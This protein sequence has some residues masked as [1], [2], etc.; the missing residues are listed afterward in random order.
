M[1]TEDQSADIEI[2]PR[3]PSRMQVTGR[4]ALVAVLI[5]FVLVTLLTCLYAFMG[6]TLSKLNGDETSLPWILEQT[7][8]MF[9]MVGLCAGPIVFLLSFA[10]LQRFRINP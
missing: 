4:N 6:V 9:K 3:Q 7:I 10:L 5:A 8:G 1:P 2:D